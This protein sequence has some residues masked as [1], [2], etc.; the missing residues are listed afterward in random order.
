M[1]PESVK[2]A[3]SIYESFD[4]ADFKFIFALFANNFIRNDLCWPFVRTVYGSSFI[5]IPAISS[6]PLLCKNKGINF[7]SA[8]K[9]L[10]DGYSAILSLVISAKR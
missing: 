7:I 1:M 9:N 8:S 2:V 10:P 4:S 3:C 6:D 5:D